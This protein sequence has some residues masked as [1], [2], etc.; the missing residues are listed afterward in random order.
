MGLVKQ[1]WMEHLENQASEKKEEWIRDRLEDPDADE[2]TKGW[3]D[4]SEEYDR[5]HQYQEFE[6]YE[7]DWAVEGKSRHEIF[8]ENIRATL[9]ILSQ[10]VKSKYE[11]NLIVML[12]AHVVASI[13]SYLS[14]TFIHYALITENHMRLLVESDPEFANRKFSVREIFTK[15]ESLKS[16]LSEYLKGL[17]FHNIEK[18]M[19]LYRKVLQV[20]FGEVS[21][22]FRAV[23]NRHNCVHRA[24]YDKEGNEMALKKEDVVKLTEDSIKLIEK[25]ESTLSNILIKDEVLWKI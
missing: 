19:P 8:E 5:T 16:D 22:L 11:K 24:G 15:R 1:H 2:E 12:Y 18:I 25:I 4:L 9:D 23:K 10:S 17:I 21:W 3:D 13:E 14:S 7:D 6:Q 20:D